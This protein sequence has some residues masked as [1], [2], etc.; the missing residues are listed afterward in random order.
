[1]AAATSVLLTVGEIARRLNEPVHRIEYVLRTRAIPARGTAGICRVYDEDD[2]HRIGDILHEIA[3]KR[4]G[5][6]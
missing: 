3:A 5:A 4:G 2:V 1:M 6:E